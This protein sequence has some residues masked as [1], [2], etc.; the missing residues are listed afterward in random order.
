MKVNLDAVSILLVQQDMADAKEDEDK[1]QVAQF[2]DGVHIQKLHQ[3][4]ITDHA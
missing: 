1:I 4:K 2:E 3:E